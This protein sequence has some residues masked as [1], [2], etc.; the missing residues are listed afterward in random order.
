MK[1][2]FLTSAVIALAIL[3]WL[4]SGY[5]TKP[6]TEFTAS[7]AEQNALASKVDFETPPTKVRVQSSSASPRTRFTVI[8]GKTE[9]KRTVDVK[10]E[11]TGRIEERLIERGSEVTEGQVLCK[12]AIEDRRVAVD[13]ALQTLNKAK[14]DYQGA[15]RLKRQGFNS[16]STIA[17]KKAQLATANAMLKR[18]EIA[19]A[20][21]KVT[22]PFDGVVENL[23][24]E[25]G[26]YAAPGNSCVTL[27]DLDPMLMIGQVS[28]KMVLDLKVGKTVFGILSNGEKVA[29]TLTFIGKQSDTATR[30]YP[31]EAELD[32]GKGL[33]RSGLTTEI[34]IPTD[35]V[36][37]HQVSPAIFTLD[38]YGKIGIRTVNE[39]NIV[40]FHHVEILSEDAQGAWVTG[41]P[42]QTNII[43]VGHELVVQGERVD[44]VLD[45]SN[46]PNQSG[47]AT[48]NSGPTDSKS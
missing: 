40:E 29:G 21:T 36:L 20:K 33:L 26:D 18:R 46:L 35:E 45:T 41:L 31:I 11:I 39:K 9:N 12:I 14:I 4:M 42:N 13:E 1:K 30:T 25:V 6:A 47:L 38:D 37:A 48:K 22:A 28:E 19:L 16:E 15:L 43:T 32:N 23:G 24:L 7:L 2:T 44:P 34:Q 27:V 8:R 5:L 3:G 10:T 17:E